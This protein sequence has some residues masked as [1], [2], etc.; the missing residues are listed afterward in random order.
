MYVWMYHFPSVCR[1]LVPEIYVRQPEMLHVFQYIDV[2][3]VCD[4]QLPSIL[5]SKEPF[6][7]CHE[8]CRQA[9]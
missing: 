9:W 4:E 8:D 6:V 2:V 5:K 1:T 7:F 3:H